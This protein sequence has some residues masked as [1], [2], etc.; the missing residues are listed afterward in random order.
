MPTIIETQK[1][2]RNTVHTSAV[3]F[4]CGDCGH[5]KPVQ[6]SGGTGYG[7]YGPDGADAK[8]ICYECCGKRDLANFRSNY[9]SN[10]IIY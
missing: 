9:K 3:Q 2:A 7:Y 6:T 4:K 10:F 8:P 5:V 1:Q